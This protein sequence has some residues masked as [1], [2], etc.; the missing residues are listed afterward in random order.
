[1]AFLRD[2]RARLRPPFRVPLRPPA[3]FLADFRPPLRAPAARLA[4]RLRRPPPALRAPDDFRAR[5]PPLSR[6]PCEPPPI[7]DSPALP[8][9]SGVG[10]PPVRSSSGFPIPLSKSSCMMR[11]VPRAVFPRALSL[12]EPSWARQALAKAF[13]GGV[14][15]FSAVA[16]FARRR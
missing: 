15:V 5:A 1:P 13:H 7:S 14:T 8:P 16:L 6:R 2:F 12:F 4:A 10:E 3:F 11:L 9:I